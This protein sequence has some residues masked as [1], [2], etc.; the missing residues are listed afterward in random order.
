MAVRDIKAHSIIILFSCCS[1]WELQNNM[2]AVLNALLLFF[3]PGLSS[4]EYA[5]EVLEP[6]LVRTIPSMPE[7]TVQYDSGYKAR[8]NEVS[9]IVA[10][11]FV[12]KHSI[13]FCAGS[14]IANRWIV[15]VASC[16]NAAKLVK[17]SYSAANRQEPHFQ[18][19]VSSKC[20]YPHPDF[21]KY[22]RNDI[23]LIKTPYVEYMDGV[24]S[25]PLPHSS[26]MFKNAW[27][28]TAGWGQHRGSN[29]TKNFLHVLQIQVLRNTDCIELGYGKRFRSKMLCGQL[30]NRE[31]SC[32]LDSGS[33][34]ELQINATLIAIASF[35]N[36]YGCKSNT[37]LGYTRITSYMAW[38][39]SIMNGSW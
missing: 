2:K 11:D 12:G 25:V 6:K 38:M 26:S 5:S 27:A 10:L 28:F 3:V 21:D 20:F 29:E 39:N 1:H 35:G 30:P 7:A 22:Y 32:H 23:A 15:T 37:P 17:I 4:V 14:I 18:M 16:T 9:Y 19:R 36:Q 24:L 8:P 31:T 13:W 33:P 34:M